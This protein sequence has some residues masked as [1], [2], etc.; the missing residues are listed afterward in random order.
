MKIIHKGE[1]KKDLWR[2]ACSRCNTVLECETHE[3][4]QHYPG[5][6]REGPCGFL[7]CPVCG[8]DMHVY[9]VGRR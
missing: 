9:P 2:G 6:Q 7:A 5:D 4:R 1:P 3:L 8:K